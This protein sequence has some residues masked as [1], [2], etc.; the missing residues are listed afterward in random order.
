MY[1]EERTYMNKQDTEIANTTF[2]SICSD[3]RQKI[4]KKNVLVT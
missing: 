3:G 4:V 2:V 1:V